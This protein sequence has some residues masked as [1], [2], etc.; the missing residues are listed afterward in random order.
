MNVCLKKLNYIY[1]IFVCLMISVTHVHAHDDQY[2]SQEQIL[3]DNLAQL[4]LPASPITSADLS[5]IQTTIH[6]AL[7]VIS[8]YLEARSSHKNKGTVQYLESSRAPSPLVVG[9]L[10]LENW[11]QEQGSIN[12]IESSLVRSSDQYIVKS[13]TSFPAKISI[14]INFQTKE[15]GIQP[16]YLTFQDETT[17]L[18]FVSLADKR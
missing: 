5:S 10:A 15:K 17:N 6:Q 8:L 4:K 7:D 3:K 9:I 12:H 2:S 18:Q 1:Y 14:G 16:Y 11:L 13:L